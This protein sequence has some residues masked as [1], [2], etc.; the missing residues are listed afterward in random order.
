M[1]TTD[2][3]TMIESMGLPYTYGF[4]PEHARP[5]PP[6]LCF[7]Y[8]GGRDFYA[9]GANYQVID[10]LHLLRYAPEVDLHADRRIQKT[11][12]NFGLSCR[13]ERWFDTDTRLWVTEFITDVDIEDD[14]D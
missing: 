5:A 7:M 6:Y 8:A 13:W 10:E 11:L 1:K 4:F 14:D 3:K 9:D 2:V 12:N